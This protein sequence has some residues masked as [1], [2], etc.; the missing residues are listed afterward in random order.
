MALSSAALWWWACFA[1]RTF[2]DGLEMVV[3]VFGE[4]GDGSL[5]S[6]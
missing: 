4:Y 6:V 5:R 1:G 3:F 2:G